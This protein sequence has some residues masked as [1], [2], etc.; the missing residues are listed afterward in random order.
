MSGAGVKPL[1]RSGRQ[2]SVPRSPQKPE[3]PG[4]M[5]C[6]LR[7]KRHDRISARQRTKEPLTDRRRLFSYVKESCPDKVGKRCPDGWAVFWSGRDAGGQHSLPLWG[8]WLSAA[9]SDE[10]VL[11]VLG[12]R[13]VF[14][15]AVP[16][17]WSFLPFPLRMRSIRSETRAFSFPFML[18]G[19]VALGC[20]PDL[21][22]G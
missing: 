6:I 19:C 7:W 21:R 4:R 20:R 11:C 10:V 16:W 1:R 14:A 13:A 3:F 8:R 15:G 2:P 12:G 18:F 9:R 22:R 5:L 17:E